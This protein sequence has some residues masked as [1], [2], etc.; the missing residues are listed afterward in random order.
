M[1]IGYHHHQSLLKHVLSHTQSRI[2][3]YIRAKVLAFATFENTYHNSL[4]KLS[5]VIA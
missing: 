3:Q 1:Q 4:F 5:I 2:L